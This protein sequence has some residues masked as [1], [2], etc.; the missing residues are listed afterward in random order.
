MSGAAART[1]NLKGKEG[2][3]CI[4]N[5]FRTFVVKNKQ[6][7]HRVKEEIRNAD[8]ACMRRCK[9][10]DFINNINNKSITNKKGIDSVWSCSE[11]RR[12]KGKAICKV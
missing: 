7:T 5:R 1:G 2:K 12:F 11:D 9:I 3:Y 8:S 6:T 10:E 4:K